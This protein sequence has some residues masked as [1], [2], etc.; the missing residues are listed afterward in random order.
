MKKK[1]L[2]FLLLTCGYFSYGQLACPTLASP[3]DGSVNVPVDT[4]IEWNGIEGAPGYLISIG[5]APD[6]TDIINNQNVGNATSYQPPLGLPDDQNIYVTI[7]I[8]FFNAENIVCASESFR[9]VDVTEPPSCTT[10]AFPSADATNVNIGT[11]IS[12]NYAP[13]ATGYRISLGTTIGGTELTNNENITGNPFFQPPADLPV[14]TEIFVTIVPYNENGPSNASCTSYSFTTGALATIPTCTALVSPVN[15]EINVA[16]SPILEW[17]AVPNANGY[18]VT[19][20]TTP[21]NANVIDNTTFTTNSSLF[22]EFE[23]NL[24]FFI[25]IIPFNAA[26]DAIG[27]TQESFSTILGCGPYFNTI[28]GEFVDLA[29]EI[30]FPD[31]VSICKNQTPFSITTED[32]AEGYRWFQ[33]DENDSETLISTDATVTFS[34][35]GRYRYEAYNTASQSGTTIECSNT[36]FFEVVASEIASNLMLNVISQNGDLEIQVQHDGIGDYEYAIDDSSG[37]YQESAIFQN[38]ILGNHIFYVR[39]KNGCGI[40]ELKF[41]QD[42]TVEGFPTFFTP[43]GD[44]INDY[45]QILPSVNGEELEVGTIEIYDRFGLLIAQIEP[46]SIGWNG[47]FNGQ[48]LPASDYW[49][50]TISSKNR[51]IQGHFSLKR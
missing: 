40:A 31:T 50:K 9:T 21:F 29:P 14:D 45:W 22:I 17:S 28:T 15:G 48:T 5:T 34:E 35:I 3:V 27:C 18:R 23:P 42:L 19:I 24:T 43:N 2:F 37:A 51:V 13:T 7:T 30:N 10:S 26:G 25:T 8:F 20:G 33:V 38:V 6:G 32:N 36:K 16:L 39:D 47:T 41:E 46:N 4:R 49:F 1:L 12:W 44:G 11:G